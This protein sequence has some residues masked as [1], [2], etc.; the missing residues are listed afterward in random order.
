[1][2]KKTFFTAILCLFFFPVFSQMPTPRLN[3]K[4]EGISMYENRDPFFKYKTFDYT[5]FF[6]DYVYHNK[7]FI[8]KIPSVK[9][10]FGQILVEKP[11]PNNS[12]KNIDNMPIMVPDE[13]NSPMKIKE[14][15]SRIKYTLLIK[16]S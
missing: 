2:I 14:F 7:I 3:N 5:S 10:F 6:K 15:D 8:P 9:L 13:N 4:I 16:D 12:F 11:I 1:M